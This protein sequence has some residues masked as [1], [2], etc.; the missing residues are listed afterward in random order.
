MRNFDFCGKWKQIFALPVILIIVGVILLCTMGLNMGVD[1][2]GGSMIYAEIGS[3]KFKV[4]DI[5]N[6][7]GEYTD[8]AVVS[9]SGDNNIGV[10]IRLGGADDANDAQSKIIAAL[11]EKYE[12]SDD[13]I[14]VEYVGPTIGRSLIVNASL[15][16]AIAFV[17]MMAYIW[18]RFELM[19]GV[20][21]LVGIAHDVL[22]MFVF[23]ILFRIQINTPFIAALLTIVGYSI[24]NT[25]II[26][27]RIRSNRE[28]MSGDVELSEIVNMSIRETLTRSINTTVTTLIALVVLYVFGVESIKTFT[29]PIII[30]V[31][32]GFFSSVFISGPMWLLMAKNKKV[33]SKTKTVKL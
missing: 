13:K 30:G 31:I 7:A 16:L 23:T 3:G 17:L 8:N 19:S 21:A 18:F 27:D 20:V 32:A 2:S 9:Y 22:M 12:I 6:L 4:D 28:K 14:N 25:I 5:R 10:D 15:A 33:K 1:F 11:K 24:N 26:F 29:L